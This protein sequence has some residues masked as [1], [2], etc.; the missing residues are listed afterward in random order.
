MIIDSSDPVE[1]ETK[2]QAKGVRACPLQQNCVT[3]TTP[4]ESCFANMSE[5]E[6]QRSKR[7]A[8]TRRVKRI[9]RYAPRRAVF[10]RYPIV[11]R[12][13]AFARRRAH[14]WS[15]KPTHVR[16]AIYFGLVLSLWPVMGV[17][18]PLALLISLF[19]RCNLMVAGGLQF[20]TNPFT[21]APIYYGTYLVG[22]YIL[23][24]T[25][26][27]G[28]ATTVAGR[29]RENVTIAIA[30]Q[31]SLPGQ[32]DWSSAFGSTVTALFV[33]GTVCGLLLAA[34]LDLIYTAGWRFEHRSHH[35]A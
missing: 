3:Q 25:G 4:S 11:G 16:P 28:G 32:I 30:P 22:R 17:Q 23:S 14:L 8:Q 18:L 20:I 33:G 29:A 7:H 10:H 9:L 12:F 6:F 2:G 35:R 1:V 27:G 31:H 13:A 24:L 19:T 5:P 15:F 21:A 26:F 34:V